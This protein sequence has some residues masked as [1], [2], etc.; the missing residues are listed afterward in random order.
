MDPSSASKQHRSSASSHLSHLKKPRRCTI[1][2]TTVKSDDNT[3]AGPFFMPTLQY[4]DIFNPDQTTQH[5]MSLR[6]QIDRG[7]FVSD[8]DWT[9]YRRN[10]FQISC[11]LSLNEAAA[12]ATDSKGPFIVVDKKTGAS[13]T[14]LQF[15]VGISAQIASERN[16]PIE[17]VQHTPKRDKG[18]QTIPQPQPIR[19]IVGPSNRT[20]G[21]ILP[22][23]AAAVKATLNDSSNIDGQIGA[24]SSPSITNICFERLQFKTATA[25]NGKRRAAQ[26]YYVLSV[27]LLAEC[28]D[29]SR[30]LIATSVSSPI[31][32]RGRSPGHYAD[33]HTGV[34]GGTSAASAA[35]S[36]VKPETV[37]SATPANASAL[38]I[39]TAR[40]PSSTVSFGTAAGLDPSFS[41][42]SSL[43]SSS[44]MVSGLSPHAASTLQP[45]Q[46][47]IDQ[48]VFPNNHP[49]MAAAAMAVA[50]ASTG[51]GFYP[52]GGTTAH[53]APFAGIGGNKQPPPPGFASLEN[54][55]LHAMM[56]NNAATA[57]HHHHQQQPPSFTIA[58][59]N[60]NGGDGLHH[61]SPHSAFMR[62]TE[63]DRVV[64]S[65]LDN[66]PTSF[67]QQQQPVSGVVTTGLAMMPPS[68]PTLPPPAITPIDHGPQLQRGP[69]SFLIPTMGLPQSAVA[70]TAAAAAAVPPA[71]W[72]SGDDGGYQ[73][74][75]L[76]PFTTVDTTTTPTQPPHPHQFM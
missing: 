41:S 53:A 47:T 17:L 43:S 52:G 40:M 27:D 21:A 3:A 19:P 45:Q 14:A 61:I 69:G 49:A 10:Y 75:S 30:Q 11:T 36:A 67:I 28:E 8:Q 4:Q 25:N 32:V 66:S 55:D 20:K 16:K 50:A 56:V 44:A 12:A 7:F 63:G 29:G 71:T 42:N 70:A 76:T 38:G 64:A 34:G 51:Y 31:V 18:P 72:G 26:Q 37:S 24:S 9:C 6:P 73:S 74:S 58:A 15:L 22:A 57:A 5:Q 2:Q 48:S 1:S 33:S 39:T 13:H 54:L 23:T 62:V 59:G 65:A 68:L 35:S 46:G 60:S